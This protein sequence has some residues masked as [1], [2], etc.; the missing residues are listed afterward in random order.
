MTQIIAPQVFYTKH[1]DGITAFVNGIAVVVSSSVPNFDLVCKNLKAKNYIDLIKL[2]NPKQT[3]QAAL[4]QVENSRIAF[5]KSELVWRGPKG[6][7]VLAGPL[8]DRIIQ[9]IRDGFSL[10]VIQPLVQLMGNIHRNKQKDIRHE[11]YEF[12]MAGKM[13]IT[14][15]GCFLAYKKVGSNFLDIYTQKISNEP[16]KFVSMPENQVNKNRNELC[17]T[18]LH[19]CARSYLEKYS[20]SSDDKVVI[21]KVNPRHVFA[22]PTDYNFAKGRCSQ[23]YVVGECMGDAQKDELFL[24]PFIFEDDLESSAPQVKFINSKKDKNIQNHNLHQV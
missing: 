23:Y 13:P 3:I 10:K 12:L 17:S 16:G 1:A 18:G 2:A 20:N 5:V 24:K 19:F 11:L 9:S 15:D 8:V 22:I 21:V 14:Q 4:D 7:E 6:N